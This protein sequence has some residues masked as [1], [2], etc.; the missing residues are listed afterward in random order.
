MMVLDRNLRFAAHHMH[1]ARPSRS[2]RSQSC[3][4][5]PL[6]HRLPCNIS[7]FGLWRQQLVSR[8]RASPAAT[9]QQVL[10]ESVGAGPPY[11]FKPCIDAHDGN[12]DDDNEYNAGPGPRSSSQVGSDV[13][14][15]SL[16]DGKYTVR[17]QLLLPASAP[18]VFALLTDYE[19]CH[20]VFGNIAASE[21]T[22][23]AEGGLQVVQTCR[24]KFLAF[25]GT[26]RVR[27]GVQ[28]DPDNGTLLFSL[29]HSNFMRDFEGRWAVR[30]IHAPPSAAASA[31]RSHPEG[32]EWCEV[33]HQLS[34][35]PSVPVPPPVSFYTRSIFVRQVKG[36]L[37]DL[38]RA[39]H[40]GQVEL[41]APR[42]TA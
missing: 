9:T 18:R 36:V 29:V 40:A 10:A 41:K 1:A 33:E 12:D 26:F 30:P 4:P 5:R 27:L 31:A 28:E 6:D 20:R 8:L 35:V 19:G 39:V 34:V 21:V 23:S 16:V 25:S 15:V 2:I 17:G 14:F 22:Q 32:E 37:V 38:Q 3:P 13:S 11:P 42:A 7:S 24:W